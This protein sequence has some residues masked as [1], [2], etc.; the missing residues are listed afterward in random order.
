LA[1]ALRLPITRRA[2]LWNSVTAALYVTFSS[3][4]PV[5]LTNVYDLAL[6][7]TGYAMA[8]F[9][10]LVVLMRPVGGWLSDRF[11][12]RRPLIAATAVLVGTT[13]VQAFT[14]PLPLVATVVLPALAVALGI[15]SGAVLA[16]V[17]A[18]T[19][20]EIIGRVGGVVTGVAGLAAF[21][22]PLLMAYSLGRYGGYTPALCLFAAAAA[23][24]TRSAITGTRQT[25]SFAS[26]PATRPEGHPPG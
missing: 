7:R 5:Y 1:T 14:P 19:P 9:V 18:V 4:L 16:Q 2:T 13:A 26:I 25:T 12:P 20:P 22:A 21:A 11:S 17:A 23:V 6:S 24:A 10:I 8:G 3:Y 15:A